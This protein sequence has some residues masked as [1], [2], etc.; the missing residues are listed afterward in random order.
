MSLVVLSSRARRLMVVVASLTLLSNCSTVDAH[1]T[2]AIQPP[3]LSPVTHIGSE[4]G[5]LPPPSKKID[6]AVYSFRDQSGQLKPSDNFARFSKAVT[7]GGAAILVDV[8]QHVSHG[9]WFTV[10]ERTHLHSLLTERQLIEQTAQSYNHTTKNVLP[11]LRFAGIIITGGVVGYDSNTVTGGYGARLLGIGADKQYRRDMVSV[12]L[13]AVSV[14]TGVVLASVETQKTIYSMALQGNVFRYVSHNRLLEL[15]SGITRNE[16]GVMAVRQAIELGVYSLIIDGAK[17]DIWSFENKAKQ[18][19]LIS[20]Y[21]N[22]E[23]AP[24]LAVGVA[25]T[26]SIEPGDLSGAKS[27]IQEKVALVTPDFG[28]QGPGKSLGQIAAM[29]PTRLAALWLPTRPLESL[30][31]P[32]EAPSSQQHYAA[33]IEGA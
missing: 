19:Q 15:E 14:S 30:D 20:K 25:K 17:R 21:D 33:S 5:N 9:R 12:E 4:L 31:Q 6:V 26:A 24:S 8:L 29:L 7:Q 10:E 1:Y 2:S 3:T 22:N 23:L 11:P 13:R 18:Q 32:S 16:P 28:T 27:K